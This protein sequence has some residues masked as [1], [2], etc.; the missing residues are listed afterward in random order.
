[1]PFLKRAKK[2]TPAS[3]S[4]LPVICPIHTHMYTFLSHYHAYVIFWPEFGHPASESLL[5]AL[6][7]FLLHI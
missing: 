4:L 2:V 3:S 6:V 5:T 7:Y 1:L